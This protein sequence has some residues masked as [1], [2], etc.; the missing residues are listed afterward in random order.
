ME[1]IGHVALPGKPECVPSALEW[2]YRGKTVMPV[3]KRC[4]YYERRSHRIV[5]FAGCPVLEASVERVIGEMIIT[6]GSA[7]LKGYDERKGRGDVSGLAARGGLDGILIG[8]ITA[9][10]LSNREFGRLRDLHQKMMPDFGVSGSVL[11]VKTTPGNF[12]WGSSFKSVCGSP[13]ATERLGRFDFGVDVSAFFQVNASQTES[14]FSRVAEEAA[15]FGASRALELYAGVGSLTAYIAETTGSVDAV[16]DWRPAARLMKENMERNGIGNVRS[17]GG[18]AESFLSDRANGGYDV[19]VMDPPR[20]GASEDVIRG[21]LRIA[22][23][24][25]IYVSCNP[26]TLARD[27]A[28]LAKGGYAV[29][30]LEAY[31]MFP[32]TAH[33]ESMCVLTRE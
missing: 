24:A 3:G 12:V 17:F 19:I 13:M 22:P 33:V 1:R 6:F 10:E 20:T 21:I 15:R 14:I 5:E 2:R 11:S 7:G 27:V 9:R 30:A 4:G 23:R 8:T 28:W 31:D 16:E 18:S 25:V 32:Q 26:A 29:S